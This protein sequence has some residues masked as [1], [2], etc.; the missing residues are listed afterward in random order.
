[1]FS[2]H[3]GDQLWQQMQLALRN[4][5]LQQLWQII[6]AANLEV[7]DPR[8]NNETKRN[9]HTKG[10]TMLRCYVLYRM[11]ILLRHLLHLYPI[12]RYTGFHCNCCWFWM[13]VFA[14]CLPVFRTCWCWCICCEAIEPPL[15]GLSR[16]IPLQMRSLRWPHV[17]FIYEINSKMLLH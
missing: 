6:A 7:T 14:T 16:G 17:P 1:M 12:L 11:F 10:L 3:C 2:R 15:L 9:A 8:H 13:H 5:K 4:V